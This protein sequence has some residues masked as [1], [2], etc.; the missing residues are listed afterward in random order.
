MLDAVIWSKI[1]R[2]FDKVKLKKKHTRNAN[3]AI[4]LFYILKSRV[5]NKTRNSKNKMCLK[6]TKKFWLVIN[7]QLT[8]FTL[9]VLDVKNMKNTKG[10]FDS[11]RLKPSPTITI[12]LV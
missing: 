12:V 4:T 7:P 9:F 3:N 8:I 2:C 11:I 1:Y 6:I 10:I 5:K